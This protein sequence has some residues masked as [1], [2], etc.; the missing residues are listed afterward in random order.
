MSNLKDYI[1]EAIS[2]GKHRSGG[3]Y[4]SINKRICFRDF[5]DILDDLG[6]RCA[7]PDGAYINE[8]YTVTTLINLLYGD[9]DQK[10]YAIQDLKHS[11][12]LRVVLYNGKE[13]EPFIVYEVDF[14]NKGRA[15]RQMIDSDYIEM[16]YKYGP[17]TRDSEDMRL[18]DL[19]EYIGNGEK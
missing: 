18:E 3:D 12:Y 11:G 15:T 17:N 19:I 10:S 14:M 16:Y 9:R 5:I 6:Y 8:R 4:N 13:K 1:E 2:S 7:V